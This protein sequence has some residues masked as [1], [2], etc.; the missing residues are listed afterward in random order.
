MIYKPAMM[1]L[2]L[3]PSL[4]PPLYSPLPQSLAAMEVLL[5][6]VVCLAAEE[7]APKNP[8]IGGDCGSDGARVCAIESWLTLFSQGAQV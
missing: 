5:V 6:R 8:S 2:L 3:W 4:E 1:S 7:Q